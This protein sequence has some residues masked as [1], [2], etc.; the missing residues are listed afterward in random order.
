MSTLGGGSSQSIAIPF[1]WC[2]YPTVKKVDD[3]PVLTK[4]RHDG[5]TDGRTVGQQRSPRYA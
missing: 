3:N 4:Y 1:E 2:G 5:Q